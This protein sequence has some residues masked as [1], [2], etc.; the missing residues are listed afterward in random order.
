MSNFILSAFADEI[1]MDLQMQMDVLDKYNIKHIEMRGVNGKGLVE[2]TLDEAKE[3]KKQ[4]DDR[5]FS[6]SAIGSPIGKIY[7]DE[8]FNPHMDL[9][10]HTIE[11]AHLM[12]T[13]YIRMF[14]FFIP[15]GEDP[16]KYRDE[17]L[18]RWNSFIN[19]AKGSGIILAHENEKDIYGD[20]AERCLD[21]LKSLNC[22]YVR[23]IFDPANFI[24]CNEITYPKAYDMLEEYIDYMHIK[25]ALYK[26]G[27]VV[28]AGY[29]DGNI[30]EILTQLYKN[31]FNCYL[32]LEPHLGH[33][34]GLDKLENDMNIEKM[35]ESGPG[36]FDIAVKAL[37]NIIND[38]EQGA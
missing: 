20:T 27:S 13:K 9:F 33:F 3:I 17:V 14:S 37:L 10:K 11:L 36:K 12:E 7:V 18:N 6:L 2:Y 24:Q 23:A 19:A 31:K 32:T 16:N 21:L 29:G 28:P 4:L 25:D 22:S 35:E 30:K 26:D 15:K 34:S 8:D 5:G 38:I 1:D